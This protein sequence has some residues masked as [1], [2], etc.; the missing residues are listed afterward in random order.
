MTRSIEPRRNR[1]FSIALAALAISSATGWLWLV[2]SSPAE[3]VTTC[4]KMPCPGSGKS[5]RGVATTP[6]GLPAEAPDFSG[7]LRIVYT[8]IMCVRAPCPPGSYSVFARD[9]QQFSARVRRIVLRSADGGEP[10]TFEG[11][12]I[13]GR[14]LSVDGDVWIDESVA[15]VSVRREIDED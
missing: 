6:D 15:H 11:R 4:I 13:G 1:R 2:M 7:S 3:A 8:P 5:T 14:G 12:Y 10:E 9:R